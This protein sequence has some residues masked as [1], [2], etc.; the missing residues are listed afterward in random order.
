M[1]NLA[2]TEIRGT[3]LPQVTIYK[4]DVIPGA[5]PASPELEVNAKIRRPNQD[6]A[7]QLQRILGLV[8]QVGGNIA[9]DIQAHQDEQN[10]A[11]AAL[12]FSAGAKNDQRFAK[13]HAYRDSWQIQGA[14]Q[15]AI[16]IGTEAQQALEERL[17]D[18][19]HPATL[20]DANAAIEGVL[21]KHLFDSQGNLIDWGTPK[22]KDILVNASNE[23]RANLLPQAAAAIKKQTDGQFVNTLVNNATSEYYRGAP[24]GVDHT[25]LT[26]PITKVDPLAPLPEPEGVRPTSNSFATGPLR[27]VSAASPQAGVA[28]V[29]SKAG[30]PSHV[31][32]G[33]LGNFHIEGGY[34]GARGDSGKAVGI[35]QW[36]PD[37]LANFERVVGKPISQATPAEQA[38]FVA[39]E[40]NN[41]TKAGMTVAQRDAILKA[42]NAKVAAHLID[43][44]YER[45]NGQARSARGAAAE[46]FASGGLPSGP[47]YVP[48]ASDP[49]LASAP[50]TLPSTATTNLPPFDFEGAMAHLPPG[51]D[52][53]VAKKQILQGLF[54]A[55]ELHGDI[56]IL[57]GLED[58]KRKDGSPSLTPD[59]VEAVIQKRDQITNKVERDSKQAQTQL[60]EDNRNTMMKAFLSDTPPSIGFIRQAV[61]TGQIDPDF[62]YTMEN[63]IESEAKQQQSEARQEARIAQADANANFDEF[64]NGKV[65]ERETG[66]GIGDPKS[67][68]ALYNSG[69]LGPVG[70][71]GALRRLHQLDAADKR[72]SSTNLQNPD[73]A[74]WFSRLQQNYGTTKGGGDLVSSAIGGGSA[75][76]KATYAVMLSH[77]KDEVAKGTPPGIAYGNTVTKYAPKSADAQEVSARRELAALQARKRLAQH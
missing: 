47:T 11:Q 77:M 69:Q 28:S 33:F 72:G 39:W 61:Q 7:E 20:A 13:S 62:G 71:K 44:Y 70:S 25:T 53:T 74:G 8:N 67:N 42:P 43:Q 64:V 68:S 54:N 36:H 17:N 60:W 45:S 76:D 27:G 10:T 9:G 66:V 3:S 2:E 26:A 32:A 59:E 51:I 31:V 30:L 49:Q 1:P 6:N 40:M 57:R 23:V 34:G 52:K 19:D 21:K 56:S 22:A 12:D 37:R 15:T 35:A 5:R 29:L 63:H 41:P 75:T 48:S 58:S 24:V 73:A 65:V 50:Q 18:L 16:T 46:Q 4:K 14:K 55:A 38:Q